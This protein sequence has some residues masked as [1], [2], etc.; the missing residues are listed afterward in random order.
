MFPDTV[1]VTVNAIAKVL[2]RINQDGYTSEYILRTS[3]NEYRLK[4]R[5]TFY[6]DKTR[7]GRRV[8]RHN[9]EFI[10][11]VFPVAPALVATIRKV[12][13]VIENDQQD[14]SVQV[15][16]HAAGLN[17]WLGQPTILRL[18]NWES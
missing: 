13:T 9:V 8:D 7:G 14:D 2:T 15:S 3:T 5:N 18:T 4:L 17:A 6:M 1:T 11:T 12:Y 10:E 16:Y